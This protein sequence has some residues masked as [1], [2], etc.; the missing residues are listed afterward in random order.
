[1]CV[2][3]ETNFRIMYERKRQNAHRRCYVSDIIA[4]IV[5][6]FNKI[7]FHFMVTS[8]RAIV[9]SGSKMLSIKFYDDEPNGNGI[10]FSIVL[11]LI[12][13]YPMKFNFIC[14]SDR[15]WIKKKHFSA[16]Q[17]LPL[18]STLTFITFCLHKKKN[19]III[20]RN[21]AMNCISN[22]YHFCWYN[23]VHI[24]HSLIRSPSLLHHLIYHT[25]FPSFNFMQFMWL[26]FLFDVQSS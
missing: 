6:K 22:Y 23:A 10:I 26:L 4:C 15:T 7:L 20:K 3:H 19:I 14:V 17:N 16:R 5:D 2:Q 13:V 1:M 18:A 9:G 25:K 8:M 12:D 24:H 11:W 21:L